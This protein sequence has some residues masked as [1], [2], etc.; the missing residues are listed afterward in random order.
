MT[1]DVTRN[2]FWLNVFDNIV[3]NEK[4]SRNKK[5]EAKLSLG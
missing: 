1:H 3:Y 4:T 2:G 5:Q